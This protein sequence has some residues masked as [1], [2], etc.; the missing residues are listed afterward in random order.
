MLDWILAHKVELIALYGAIVTAASII[1]KLTPT[2]KDDAVFGRIMKFIS[3]YVA[4]N[5]EMKVSVQKK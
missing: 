1:V 5:T 4:L 2:Q 3:K